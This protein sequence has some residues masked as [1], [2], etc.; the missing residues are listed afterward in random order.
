MSADAGSGDD[1]VQ[2]SA[3]LTGLRADTSYVYALV[4]TNAGGTTFG[5][6]ETFTTA[7]SSCAAQ[8][9]T[10][11]ADRQ[12]IAQDLLASRGDR[13]AVGGSTQSDRHQ[14]QSDEAVA[15]ADAQALRR[16]ERAVP[17]RTVTDMRGADVALVAQNLAALGYYSGSTAKA[18]V[19]AYTRT[20]AAAVRR[21]QAA[22]GIEPTGALAPDQVV[23]LPGPTRIAAIHGIVGGHA[24]SPVLSLSGTAKLVNF[25]G[26]GDLRRGQAVRIAVPGATPATGRIRSVSPDG[27]ALAAQATID[28][29]AALPASKSAVVTV[30]TER[31]PRVLAVPV[32]ALVARPGGGYALQLPGGYQL[33]VR[34]GLIT[35]DLA[36]V[37]ANG[38]RA[39]M[40][41]VTA[42]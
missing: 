19:V 33:R 40:Q 38:L 35:G 22:V 21:W 20:L 13:A 39:G 10:I 25:H 24:S 6:S 18:N 41:V 36:E 28:N 31:R 9:Q 29:P 34:V 42:A 37:S 7:S 8:H 4:A 17:H 3:L 32:E 5:T 14:V 30:T 11:T 15:R 23:I 27:N 2:V 16:A 26:S 1:P 12:A